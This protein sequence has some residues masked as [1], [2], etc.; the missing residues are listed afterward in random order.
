MEHVKQ[1]DT[2]PPAATPDTV[3]P[4]CFAGGEEKNGVTA[5]PA[6]PTTSAERSPEPA[7][8]GRHMTSDAAADDGNRNP[9][10]SLADDG[11]CPAESANATARVQEEPVAETLTDNPVL[12][13]ELPIHPACAL[14][15]MMSDDRLKEL[16]ED[17]KKNGLVHPIVVHNGQIVDGRNR[18]VAC[19]MAGVKP[20]TI[21]WRVYY[22]GPM[23]LYDWMWSTNGTRRH[24]TADQI[25][26]I[27]A[28]LLMMETR[29]QARQRQVDAGREQGE[30]GR[31]GGRG[32]KKPLPMNPSEGVS[33][34]RDSE[35]G[36]TTSVVRRRDRSG[37]SRANM[38]RKAGVSEHK[39]Q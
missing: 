13:P 12:E 7:A 8:P 3:I 14:F 24:M 21:E 5:A 37:E 27:H 6:E 26:V 16:A 19:G 23:S 10:P 31:K 39:M 33:A 36:S 1:N 30:H 35:G 32:N 29:E 4:D 20:I 15:P 17:V 38:A 9:E 2:M 22:P 34:S 18:Y 28:Q 11:E 25:A